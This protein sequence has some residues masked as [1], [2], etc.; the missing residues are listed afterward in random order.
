M[1]AFAAAWAN[2][3]LHVGY[4]NQALFGRKGRHLMRFRSDVIGPNSL[5]SVN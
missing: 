1:Y 2:L 3:A 5:K 4:Y